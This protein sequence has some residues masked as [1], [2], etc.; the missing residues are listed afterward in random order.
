MVSAAQAGPVGLW[1]F[2]SA[3]GTA[4]LITPNAVPGGAPGVLY[5]GAQIVYDTDRASNVVETDGDNDYVKAGAIVQLLQSATDFTWAF[6][7][8]QHPSQGVNVE[9]ILGNRYHIN[10]GTDYFMKVTPVYLEYYHLGVNDY[11]DYPDIPSD[12]VWRHHAVVKRGSTLSYY[13]D[14]V[15]QNSRTVTA[16]M[17]AMPFYVAGDPYGECWQGRIDDVFLANHALT[18]AE[19]QQ[20]RAGNFAPFVFPPTNPLIRDSFSGPTIN[21]LTWTVIEKGLEK[22]GSG[23]AG[24]IQASINSDGQLLISGTANTNYWGGITLRS[25]QAFPRDQKTVFAVERISLEGTGSAY[26]SS[27][28]IWGDSG[29][30]LHFSQNVGENGWSYNWNDQGGLG[31][32]PT[33]SGVNIGVLDRLDGDR[34]AHGM[35]LVFNPLGDSPTHVMIEMYLDNQLVAS[36][37]FTNWTPQQFYVMITG[38]AR[39]AG[40][41]VTAIFDNVWV[42]VPEPSSYVLASIGLGLVG[43]VALRRKARR[44]V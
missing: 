28:W 25:A 13:R 11:L 24:T 20:V 31:G 41:T 27:I 37:E 16:D 42:W 34:G 29:H 30:Y 2:D 14:G 23:T 7:A 6:W 5:N 26:R 44:T 1:R 36:Q 39:A 10:G 22:E 8:K 32:V 21:N 18:A 4:L 19:I 17:L 38:Q 12:N 40:D 9:V 35:M 33:G 3:S 15:L 43:L